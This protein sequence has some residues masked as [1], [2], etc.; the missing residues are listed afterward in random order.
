M[1][2]HLFCNDNYIRSCWTRGHAD[3]ELKSRSEKYPKNLY[4]VRE[5]TYTAGLGFTPAVKVGV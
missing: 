3:T 1:R 4:E 5:G 2:F